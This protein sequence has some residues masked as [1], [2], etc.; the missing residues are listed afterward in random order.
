MV[1]MREEPKGKAYSVALPKLRQSL[2]D[3]LALNISKIEKLKI[4]KQNQN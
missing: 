2:V 1:L 3:V 4:R